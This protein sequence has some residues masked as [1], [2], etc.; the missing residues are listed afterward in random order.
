[1]IGRRR[2]C[3]AAAALAALWAFPMFA[4]INTGRPVLIAIAMS[5]GMIAFAA[6]FAPMGAYLPEMFATRYRY[7]GASIAYNASGI[8]GGGISPLLATQMIAS[9]GSSLPVSA[10]IVLIAAISAMC[11]WFLG[12]TNSR[13]LTLEPSQS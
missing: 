10:Y 9:T 11:L 4:L 5:V 7:T 2:V 13:D 8:V 3:L 1:R 6:L 12:E